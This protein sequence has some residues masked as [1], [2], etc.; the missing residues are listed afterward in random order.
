MNEAGPAK[1]LHQFAVGVCDQSLGQAGAGVAANALGMRH[2]FLGQEGHAGKGA[3]GQAGG[4][5]G[6]PDLRQAAADGI[7][8]G[9]EGFDGVQ[10]GRQQLLRRHLAPCDQL[11]EAETILCA[12]SS[13][14]MM[15]N[16]VL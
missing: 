16:L 1:A 8:G 5:R 7:D 4:D 2:Q 12:Y 15:V 3:G 13:G 10:R 6:R 14:V 9:V 11:R